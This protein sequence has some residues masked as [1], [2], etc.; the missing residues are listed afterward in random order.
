L[1]SSAASNT[2]PPEAE[3]PGAQ[4]RQS[5]R[6]GKQRDIKRSRSRDGV[7]WLVGEPREGDDGSEAGRV[8][9]FCVAGGM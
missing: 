6:P 5:G 1:L 9:M 4:G 8:V 7:G 2:P 3:A